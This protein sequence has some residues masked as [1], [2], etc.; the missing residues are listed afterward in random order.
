MDDD[1]LDPLSVA[2]DVPEIPYEAKELIVPEAGSEYEFARQNIARV[3][4]KAEETIDQFRHVARI[5]EHP[6]AA[7]VLGGLMKMYIDA[8]KDLLEIKKKHQE[9]TGESSPTHVQNNLIMT[10]EEL[11]RMLKSKSKDVTDK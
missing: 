3:I 5:S 9:I 2:L 7:E 11:L 8:N 1:F 6:R 4:G 10:S